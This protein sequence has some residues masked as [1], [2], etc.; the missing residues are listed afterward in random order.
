MY[1]GLNNKAHEL[2]GS[3]RADMLGL[4]PELMVN[5]LQGAVIKQNSKY[6]KVVE[7]FIREK[8]RKFLLDLTALIHSKLNR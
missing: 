4:I 7:L 5:G 6:T 1:C 2:D 3:N 8:A